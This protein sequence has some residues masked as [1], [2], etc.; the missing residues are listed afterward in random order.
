MLPDKVNLDLSLIA[1]RLEGLEETIIYKL[2]DRAQFCLNARIYEP[3]KSGFLGE[4]RRSLFEIR[5]RMQE[6]MDAQ[7]G[8]FMV[9]EERPFTGELPPSRRSVSLPD[10]GLRLEKYDVVNLCG[11]IM[12]AYRDL[13]RRLCPAGDDGQYG[14]GVEH[15]VYALQAIGRRVHYGALYVG[16]SKFRDDPGKFSALVDKNDSSAL[17]AALTR[18]EVENAIIARV[19]VKAAAIQA[20]ANKIVRQIIDPEIIV[21]FYRDAVIPLTKEG[22]VLYLKNRKR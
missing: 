19:R 2:L 15:D 8:R 11:P 1:A 13:L 7:F 21:A 22:E 18:Q 16:E 20:Q 5:L 17:L 6:Q 9:P 3:G 12:A 4:E 10:T 14:S